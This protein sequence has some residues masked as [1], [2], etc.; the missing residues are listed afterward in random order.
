M[1]FLLNF[2]TN[3]H[4]VTHENTVFLTTTYEPQFLP[5]ISTVRTNMACLT[6]VMRLSTQIRA[7]YLIIYLWREEGRRGG[8][9]YADV[10][11][12]KSGVI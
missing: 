4:G 11:N 10:T 5:F 9:R 1:K 12:I 7:K 3:A 8:N 6:T 2:C